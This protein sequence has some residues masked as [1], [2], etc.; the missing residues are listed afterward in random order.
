MKSRREFLSE[1]FA[2]VSGFGVASAFSALGGRFAYGETARSALEL[3]PAKDESTGLELIRLPEGFRYISY[4]WTK[5]PMS[6]GNPTPPAHDGM[7]VVSETDG[8]VTLVRNHEVSGDNGALRLQDGKPYDSQAGGGCTTLRFDGGAGKWLDSS[9]CI[10]GTSRNCAGGVTPW[11]TWLTAEETVLGIG[12]RDP[13]KG[14]A[15]RSFKQDHGWIFEVDPRGVKAP[16][17]LK[18]MGRFVHEAVAIDRETGIV[19]ETE[20]RGSAGFYRFVP[21]VKGE[22]AAGGQ[23]QIAE[24]VGASDL[25]GHLHAGVEFDIRWHNIAEPTLANTPGLEKPDELGVFKQ[26]KKL[27]GTTFAR[28]EGCWS[29]DGQI[30]FDATSGGGAKAGQIWQYDPSK[31]KLTL[32]FESPGK[33][34]LNMPDNLCVNPNGGLILCED[35]DYG[36]DEYPQRIHLLSQEG[37]LLPLAVNDIQL[38]GEKGFRGDF[39]GREWAGATFS[40]DG[41]WLFANIQTPGM[42]LAITGP[43][44]SLTA[45][46]G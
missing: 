4:G 7:G 35:G 14:N 1:T 2:S 41:K 34:V 20:D 3:R 45:T 11:G 6:D 25:R 8:V 36:E 40:P 17:P 5:D 19:Y 37:R 18:A 28:L 32:L 16:V 44:E 43:W 42:T 9:V 39:R 46:A 38:S 23:L 33:D 15:E 29:G 27:G 31:E 13:Y 26:G 21:K 24:A 22:L 12:S 30:Y 10:S